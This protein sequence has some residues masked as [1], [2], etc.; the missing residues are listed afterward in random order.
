MKPE[1]I[2]L[3]KFLKEEKDDLQRKERTSK[4]YFEKH[5]E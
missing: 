3:T 4:Y 1:E 2:K 5:P